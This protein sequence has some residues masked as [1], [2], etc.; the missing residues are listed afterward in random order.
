MTSLDNQRADAQD[1]V[2][3]LNEA[4]RAVA[5]ALDLLEGAIDDADSLENLELTWSNSTPDIF[6]L[7][8]QISLESAEFRF[9]ETLES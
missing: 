2:N 9:T 6:Y 4:L 7:T 3:E 5:K 1:A 8:N